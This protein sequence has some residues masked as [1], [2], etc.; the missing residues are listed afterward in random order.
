MRII[1]RATREAKLCAIQRLE[2]LANELVTMNTSILD[3]LARDGLEEFHG[4]GDNVTFDPDPTDLRAAQKWYNAV[5][6]GTYGEI[7]AMLNRLEAWSVYFTEGVAD[8][9]VAFGP[10]APLLRSWVAQYYAVLLLLR[11]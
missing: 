4:Y 3:G 2:E 8:H 9:R 1:H 6:V 7:I 11:A 5:S 10:I